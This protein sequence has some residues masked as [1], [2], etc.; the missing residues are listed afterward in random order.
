MKLG[1]PQSDRDRKWNNSGQ[2]PAVEFSKEQVS[3]TLCMN[4]LCLKAADMVLNF[5][6]IHIMPIYVY[7]TEE[8]WRRCR[9]TSRR[10]Q[11]IKE[12]AEESSKGTPDLSEH[13]SFSIFVSFQYNS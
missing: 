4:M 6:S 7:S 1:G 12:S 9:E 3:S 5:K 8:I 13:L 2:P 10:E 11:F